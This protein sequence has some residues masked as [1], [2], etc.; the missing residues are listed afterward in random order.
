MSADIWTMHET[1]SSADMQEEKVRLRGQ[2]PPSFSHVSVVAALA[3][4][5]LLFW[6]QFSPGLLA[7]LAGII[8]LALLLRV[9]RHTYNSKF[10]DPLQRK[11]LSRRFHLA[12]FANGVLW[13][14]LAAA[15]S[16]RFT[17]PD[18]FSVITIL[19]VALTGYHF[20]S[21][22]PD[23]SRSFQFG[24]VACATL[25]LLITTGLPALPGIGLIL[26]ASALLDSAATRLGKAQRQALRLEHEAK[27]LRQELH[28]AQKSLESQ[29]QLDLQEENIARHVFQQLTL[30]S[31]HDLPGVFTWNEPM[32][33]LSG[34]LIQVAAGPNSDIYLF[35]G[36]FTGHGLPA[37]LGAVPAS[38][39]FRTM[40]AKG[41]EIPMIAEELNRKLHLLLPTGYFCCAAIM[42]FSPDRS[43]F[44]LWNG[45]LPP[46]LISRHPTGAT[47]KIASDNLPLGILGEQDF[48]SECS[49]WELEEGDRV[50][51][52]SDGLT[53]A[54]DVHGEMWG[55]E[56]LSRCLS[57]NI[58][59]CS[60]I[61]RLKSEILA[62]GHQAQQAD[63][64]SVIEVVAGRPCSGRKV[65]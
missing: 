56:R 11:L 46:L 49:S 18:A 51:V 22:A 4:F 53:E 44:T 45:G 33:K 30:S 60:I 35:L 48:S 34:D 64:L 28:A 24:L 41:I 13:G 37:A 32:G 63:D 26:I 7:W 17:H 52:Y 27:Q 62:F 5:G 54:E 55:K 65:A 58:T 21:A 50:L 12:V 1:I 40:V 25:L 29:R 31:D 36:D 20:L 10:S 15:I 19:C 23:Y 2:P 38:T 47:T 57:E 3:I 8:T 9:I 61:E 59:D 16:P 6:Q 14:S 39:I 43:R 42:K